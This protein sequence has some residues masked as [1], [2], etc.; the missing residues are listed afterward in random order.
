MIQWKNISIRN[1]LLIYLLLYSKKCN[2]EIN[3]SV[4]KINIFRYFGSKK[5]AGAS[6]C[7]FDPTGATLILKVIHNN[8]DN[9][10]S[11]KLLCLGPRNI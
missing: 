3:L 5:L 11:Y 9:I 10:H 8:C 2:H 7:M 6:N 4:T 1:L